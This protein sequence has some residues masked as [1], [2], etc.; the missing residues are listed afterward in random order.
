MLQRLA[1]CFERWKPLGLGY[2]RICLKILSFLHSIG[3]QRWSTRRAVQ[4]CVRYDPRLRIRPGE[5]LRFGSSSEHFI[6]AVCAFISQYRV[7]D[8]ML[9][10]IMN[11]DDAQVSGHNQIRGR[12]AAA[13]RAGD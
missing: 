11:A 6:E 1:E 9:V 2:K 4:A 5:D 7:P 12:I 3:H 10:V 13:C 8:N